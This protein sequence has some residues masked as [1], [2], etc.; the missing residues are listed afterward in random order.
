[1]DIII[2][3][4]CNSFLLKSNQTQQCSG[5][6]QVTNDQLYFGQLA[7]KRCRA[8]R[9]YVMSDYWQLMNHNAVVA[10]NSSVKTQADLAF[11]QFIQWRQEYHLSECILVY[12]AHYSARQCSLIVTIA[13][14]AGIKVRACVNIA[15]CNFISFSSQYDKQTVCNLDIQLHTAIVSYI[16]LTD[17]GWTVINPKMVKNWGAHSIQK[18]W[19]ELLKNAL[20]TSNR[21]DIG[22]DAMIEQQAFDLFKHCN[23]GNDSI[24]VELQSNNTQFRTSIETA[25]IKQKLYQFISESTSIQANNIILPEHTPELLQYYLRNQHSNITVTKTNHNG[26]YQ[27]MQNLEAQLP[28]GQQTQL[29]THWSQ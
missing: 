4:D 22:H 21:F 18:R 2:I 8:N 28:A 25:P 7:E 11:H 1:M 14:Q 27:V 26:Y 15:L 13:Q 24:E 17:D 10:I 20:L 3:N 16:Q 5:F 29:I 19:L 23:L 12:P 6:C 9:H